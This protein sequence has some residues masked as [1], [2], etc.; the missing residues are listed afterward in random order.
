MIRITSAK[1]IKIKCTEHSIA[2]F[3]ELLFGNTSDGHIYFNASD[4]LKKHNPS[5]SVQDFFKAYSYPIQQL[6]ILWD[7]KDSDVYRMDAEGNI[8]IDGNF[9]YL[10]IS[11]V[12]PEF[13][14][15]MIESMDMLFAYGVVLTDSNILAAAKRR[16]NAEMLNS[17]ERD[18]ANE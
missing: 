12:E 7:M 2:E 3:P 9:S 6:Q 13:L 5:T 14:A 1:I 17:E 8:L 11:F 10:F 18:D 4:Y 15:Y 16:I